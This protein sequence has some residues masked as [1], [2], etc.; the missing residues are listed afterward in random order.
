LA[1]TSQNVE[2]KALVPS[3]T[4]FDQ[5]LLDDLIKDY[6]E[7]AS[8]PYVPAPI[9]PK[10]EATT[11]KDDIQVAN[12]S[13]T[14][15]EDDSP[16][17]HLPSIQKEGEIDRKLKKLIKDYGEYD[18]YSRQSPVNLKTGVI[19]AFLLLGVIFGAF[20]FFSA[21]KPGASSQPAAI[22][23]AAETSA[24]T[25]SSVRKNNTLDNTKTPEGA[26]GAAVG[27]P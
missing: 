1:T 23:E 21:P 13:L 3:G 17:R 15:D 8:S 27:L 19:G 22:T 16:T 12:S 5:R 2:A 9:K 11:V 20:Y 25:G 10:K 7:F 18:L 26:G 4:D 6:G 14:A 24:P